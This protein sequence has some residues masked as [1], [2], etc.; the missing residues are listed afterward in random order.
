MT[1]PFDKRRN[2][3]QPLDLRITSYLENFDISLDGIFLQMQFL[4]HPSP[5]VTSE[6]TFNYELERYEKSEANPLLLQELVA[7]E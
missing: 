6:T 1:T 2:K 7:Q 3:M 4:N 5:H